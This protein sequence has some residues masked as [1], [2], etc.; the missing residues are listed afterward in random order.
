KH[1]YTK[2]LL[3]SIPMLGQRAQHGRQRLQEISGI[4]PSLY[5]LPAGCSFYPRCPDAMAVCQE[6]AP[7]LTDL[8]DGHRVRCWLY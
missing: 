1:P 7:E 6:K 8:G 4:V 2:G 5:E 3:K